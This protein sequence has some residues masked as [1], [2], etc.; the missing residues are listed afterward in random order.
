MLQIYLNLPNIFKGIVYSSY[1]NRY[2]FFTI[3]GA[4]EFII[5][6]RP[7]LP[8]IEISSMA[9]TQSV[10]APLT[11]KDTAVLTGSLSSQNGSGS[12]SVGCTMRHVT[13]NNGWV[14]VSILTW[15]INLT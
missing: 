1:I 3:L 7:G 15:Y 2:H 13:S 6:Y 5:L 4:C 10:E 8:R 14:E 12:G 9:I 11:V